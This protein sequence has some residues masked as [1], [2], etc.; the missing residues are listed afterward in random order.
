MTQNAAREWAAPELLIG[1]LDNCPFSTSAPRLQ[2][3]MV[4]GLLAAWAQRVVN[5]SIATAHGDIAKQDAVDELQAEAELAGLIEAFGQDEIQRAIALPF[6]A[7]W[8]EVG[9]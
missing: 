8:A 9:P 6:D 3:F 5:L 4:D 1:D 2:I 7:I